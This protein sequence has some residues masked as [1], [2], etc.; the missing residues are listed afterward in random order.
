MLSTS[1]WRADP[2][3]GLPVGPTSGLPDGSFVAPR[4]ARR[5]PAAARRLPCSAAHTFLFPV[6]LLAALAG[7]GCASGDRARSGFLEPYKFSIPQG[8]YLNQQMLDQVREGMSREQVRLAIGSP[9]L[10]DVFH[11]NRWDYVFRFQYPNGDAELRKVTIEFRD[12]RVA[13]VRA[14]PLPQRDD[15]ND[16]A[17]PGYQPKET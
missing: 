15:P 1:S 5:G 6:L 16:P 4:A 10:T 9:L 7:G 17:L 13:R 3:D 12:D 11:P 8:N 2:L 14:D